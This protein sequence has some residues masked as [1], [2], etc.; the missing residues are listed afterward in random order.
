[1]S[2]EFQLFS[3]GTGK[4]VAESHLHPHSSVRRSNPRNTPSEMSWPIPQQAFTQVVRYGLNA[5]GTTSL[6]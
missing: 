2:Q 1:M 5:T 4:M 3:K 6:A